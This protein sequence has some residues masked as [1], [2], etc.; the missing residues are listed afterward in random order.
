MN[1]LLASHN[2]GKIKEA[3]QLLTGLS[4]ELMSLA[5]FAEL[6]DLQVA[7][8]GQ[9]FQE[10][11]LL[12]AR[13]Y[14][15]KSGLA[16]I[17]TDAGLMVSVL[18]GFP[19]VDSKRWFKGT[20]AERNQ[21]LLKKL[22]QQPDRRARFVT[23]ACFYQPQTQQKSFFTGEVRGEISQQP[24]GKTGFGYDPIF[25]PQGYQQTFAQLGLETKN[26]LSHRAQAMKQLKKH[27]KKL[28]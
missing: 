2:Q 6:K 26:Q 13:F 5:D 16:T 11:A 7:E 28:F 4:L 9:T 15:Q 21:A 1:L 8:T 25:I 18:A 19:G 14:A 12:K 20:D 17:A 10:N 22:A 27:L 23:V 24:Q 3:R